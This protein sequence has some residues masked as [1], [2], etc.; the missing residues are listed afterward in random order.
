MSIGA[1]IGIIVAWQVLGFMAHILIACFGAE[2]IDYADG[3]EYLNPVYIHKQVRVNWFGAIM[4]TL[5]YTALCP[6]AAVCY[7]FYKLCTVGA[8]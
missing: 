2:H 6:F 3:L 1:I 7:W 5:F 8:K 4:I